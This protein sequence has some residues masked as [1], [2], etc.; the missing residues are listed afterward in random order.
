MGRNETAYLLARALQFFLP[1]VPQVYYVGLLAGHNDMELLARTQVGRDINRHHYDAAEIARDCERPVVRR[2]I[3]LI[4]LRNRHA[5]FNGRFFVEPSA[6]DVIHL[7]WQNGAAR[8][9]LWLDFTS[10]A[11]RLTYT[12]EEG[13]GQNELSLV[14][15]AA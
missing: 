7:S 11:H 3:E 12:D 13:R 6:D 10:L 2:L 1:G 8:A 9:S 4:R 15:A 14:V 5:A